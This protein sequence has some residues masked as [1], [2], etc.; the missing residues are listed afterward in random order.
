MA[1][2]RKKEEPRRQVLGARPTS[3][4]RDGGVMS[5]LLCPLFSLGETL[6]LYM[7][8]QTACRKGGKEW[9]DSFVCL[10]R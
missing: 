2:R 6:P 1:E 4:S 9:W 7:L 10:W 8:G 5:L 3:S